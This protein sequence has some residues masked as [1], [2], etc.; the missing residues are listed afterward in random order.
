MRKVGIA[1]TRTKASAYGAASLNRKIEVYVH[2]SVARVSNPVGWSIKVAG[3]SFIAARKTRRVPER[4]PGAA[5]GRTILR[6]VCERVCPR[7]AE[8]STRFWG[9]RERLVRTA[10]TLL[11]MK[12][13]A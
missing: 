9:T 13:K 6:K 3:S 11:A 4:I 10:P 5:S 12:S 8:I 2:I 7:V 1:A